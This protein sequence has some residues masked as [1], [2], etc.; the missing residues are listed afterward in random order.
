ML[1]PMSDSYFEAEDNAMYEIYKDMLDL[2]KNYSVNVSQS[3]KEMYDVADKAMEGKS[4][5]LKTIALIIL[6]SYDIYTKIDKVF[7]TLN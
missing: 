1:S 2:E 3:I 4:D 5:Y 7:V 6:L